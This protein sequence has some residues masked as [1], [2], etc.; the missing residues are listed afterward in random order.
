MTDFGHEQPTVLRRAETDRGEVV[1]RRRVVDGVAVHELITNGAFAMD[2]RETRT[3][4]LLAAHA[5]VPAGG[6][7]LVGGLGLGYTA[8]AF[9]QTDV[10]RLVVV[11]VEDCLVDW[12]H[13]GVTPTL[14]GVVA[15][16]R[17]DV[18][19]ADVHQF[20]SDEATTTDA[21]GWDAVVLDVDNGPDFL[22]HAHNERIYS[23]EALR[24]T[25][26]VLAPGGVLVLWCQGPH[27][28]LHERLRQVAGAADHVGEHL[29]PIQREGR[30]FHYALYAL[31]RGLPTTAGRSVPRRPTRTAG[32]QGNGPE[33]AHD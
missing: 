29:Y 15:D 6:R 22:I 8:R 14:A 12:A 1:L 5:A 30:E 9:L 19:V 13:E 25:V 2:S 18:R 11:E 28:T 31:S 26:A 27:P 17:V 7:V 10:A 16:P 20:L 3:E 23:T 4:E 32:P 21:T 33:C 24:R